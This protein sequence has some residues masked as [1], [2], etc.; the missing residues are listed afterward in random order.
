MN[1]NDRGTSYHERGRPER[2]QTRANA[3]K[4][5][6]YAYRINHGSSRRARRM[7][8]S[9]NRVF[10]T[11][12]VG[13]SL[14]GVLALSRLDLQEIYYEL[15]PKDVLSVLEPLHVEIYQYSD[16]PLKP[17]IF[18]DYLAEDEEFVV[19]YLDGYPSVETLGDFTIPVFV[20]DDRG[21]SVEIDALLS[22]RRGSDIPEILGVEDIFVILGDTVSYRAGV[23]A[24]DYYGN[25]LDIQIDNTSVNVN[26]EGEYS[27]I[28]EAVDRFGNIAQLAATVIVYDDRDATQIFV[29]DYIDDVFTRIFTAEMTQREQADAIYKWCKN[30]I[31]YASSG[32]NDDNY[33]LA[34]AAFRG[35]SGDCYTFFA[36]EYL[37]LLQA[38][39]PVIP[40]ERVQGTGINHKWVAVNTG[41]GW[42]HYDTCPTF[43]G[44]WVFMIGEVKAGQ[45]AAAS[46]LKVGYQTRYFEYASL[47][48][49]V[50]IEDY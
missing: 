1:K 18:I 17:E 5:S 14:L 44:D 49:G 46:D 42:Y 33:S 27:V 35:Q 6:P 28:Y 22:V 8:S 21:Q 31:R 2:R 19:G 38:E 47:P 30:N 7:R 26:V 45:I 15:N 3:T 32:P 11:G 50:V 34:Y 16:L 10:V 41:D 25:S 23:S 20:Q 43:T 4:P 9:R 24:T 13:T 40:L 29:E 12:L 48:E 36:V 39:I 37:M